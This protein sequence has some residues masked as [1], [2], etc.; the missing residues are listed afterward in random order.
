MELFVPQIFLPHIPNVELADIW[1][2]VLQPNIVKIR[3]F[4][5]PST[6]SRPVITSRGENTVK[7][8]IPSSEFLMDITQKV[9]HVDLHHV[10][11]QAGYMYKNQIIPFSVILFDLLNT[12]FSGAIQ[13]NLF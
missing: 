8:Q 12:Y 6:V 4:G 1:G 10:T 5:A 11:I 3:N 7:H 13:H 2:T 9:S